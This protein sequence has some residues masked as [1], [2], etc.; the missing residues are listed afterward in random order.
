MGDRAATQRSCPRNGQGGSQAAL[1]KL[2]PQTTASAS[3]ASVS[4][5]MAQLWSPEQRP[6]GLMSV[7]L[8]QLFRPSS[9]CLYPATLIMPLGPR[10]LF[11]VLIWLDSSLSLRIPLLT[12]A[13]GFTKAKLS[14][15]AWFPILTH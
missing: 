15:L 12:A 8:T 2:S 9:L 13:P 10:D 6:V 3:P 11:P 7:G 4:L 5:A 1:P 14:V